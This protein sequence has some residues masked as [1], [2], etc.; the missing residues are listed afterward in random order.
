MITLLSLFANRL[1]PAGEELVTAG[2]AIT[3]VTAGGALLFRIFDG[4]PPKV[5]STIPEVTTRRDR[6]FRTAG[7]LLALWMALLILDITVM[8]PRRVPFVSAF[9]LLMGIPIL[10]G[11]HHVLKW[12]D[13]NATLVMIN[14]WVHW[15]YEP[16]EWARIAVLGTGQQRLGKQTARLIA[17]ANGLLLGDTFLAWLSRGSGNSRLDKAY[18]DSPSAA[19]VFSFLHFGKTTT[20]VD[21]IA[22]LP[23]NAEADLLRLQTHLESLSHRPKVHLV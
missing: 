21:Y 14:P 20:Q 4:P 15:E 3:V 23:A 11:F 2:V 1:S 5:P 18:R 7:V 13:R 19:V 22:P 10:S 12:E 8:E 17:G 9:L 6:F 16:Y